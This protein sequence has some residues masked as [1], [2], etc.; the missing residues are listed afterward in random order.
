MRAYMKHIGLQEIQT[1]G[2]FRFLFPN[3]YDRISNSIHSMNSWKAD[4][5]AEHW[6]PF[7]VMSEEFNEAL[8]IENLMRLS[9]N[10][11]AITHLAIIHISIWNVSFS[12]LIGQNSVAE[13]L[14]G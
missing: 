5:T 7:A 9:A 3:H 12:I 2:Q 8:N 4:S 14:S 6:Q 1:S 11:D 13:W 10:D